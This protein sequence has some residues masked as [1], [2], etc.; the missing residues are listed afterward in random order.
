MNGEDLTLE[1]LWQ[2]SMENAKVVID[3]KAFN[4]V[5]RSREI[6]DRA[7][8]KNQIIYGITTGFG[9]LSDIKISPKDIT[10]LQT[11]RSRSSEG[12]APRSHL[13]RTIAFAKWLADR[14]GLEDL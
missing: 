7:I 5:D 13:G 11:A 9:K 8:Q 14:K 12:R 6:V 1:Q 3:E 2:I 4:I 10:Q